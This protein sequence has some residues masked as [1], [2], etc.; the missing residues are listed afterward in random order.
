[1]AEILS[2]AGF[3]TSG[4]I[5]NPHAGAA[6]LGLDRGFDQCMQV[7]ALPKLQDVRPLEETT[8]FRVAWPEDVNEQIFAA[9][10]TFKKKGQFAYVHYLQPH[11]PYDPPARYVDRFDPDKA[12]SCKCG[13]QTWTKLHE[14]FE[15]AN[16]TGRVLPNDLAHLIAQY[17]ANLNY[18]DDAFGE[19]IRKL[20]DAGLYDDSLII[21][22]S[23]HG[24]A[25]FDHH[26]FGHNVHLYDDMT[27]I[28]LIMKFPKSDEV[29]PR[30]LRSLVETVDVLPTV[31]DFLNLDP[32][33]GLEG[34]S[35]L[36]LIT[37]ATDHLKDPEVVMS[38]HDL[39]KHAIRLGDHKYIYSTEDDQ[40][41][42][43]LITDPREQENLF[44][45]DKEKAVLLRKR[46]EQ[47]IDL[48]TGSTQEEAS[49]IRSDPRMK[50]LLETLGYVEGEEP[51]V[52]SKPTTRP[53]R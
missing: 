7:Y 37:G 32:P 23:D 6:A 11:K 24:D 13:G 34:E 16:R 33:D 20:K 15:E 29:K 10:P 3:K 38:T 45:K 9:L 5:A 41:L 22:M 14:K 27:R 35:L 26:R 30:R 39:R 31:I 21:L 42:Y 40:E 48:T 36:P 19:L 28:P 17:R 44:S 47:I 12:G 51:S 2:D 49:D 8:R 43:N 25:F 50:R 4:F 46:L 18:V 1:M 52:T 53:A